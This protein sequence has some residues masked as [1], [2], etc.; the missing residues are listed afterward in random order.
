MLSIAW[1][2]VVFK[3]FWLEGGAFRKRMVYHT[4]RALLVTVATGIDL[5]RNGVVT[6]SGRN[7]DS[8]RSARRNELAGKSDDYHDAQSV[9]RD[10]AS[11][12]HEQRQWVHDDGADFYDYFE[13]HFAFD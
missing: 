2:I 3:G 10:G 1:R 5:F 12:I 8:K 13:M 7:S 11:D 6:Q 9:E 4:V